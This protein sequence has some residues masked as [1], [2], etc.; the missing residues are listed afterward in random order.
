[1]DA[2]KSF[3]KSIQKDR[4][5][6]YVILKVEKKDGINQF[7]IEDGN[8]R[9]YALRKLG[10]NDVMVPVLFQFSA[11]INI[12]ELMEVFYMLSVSKIIDVRDFSAIMDQMVIMNLGEIR[13]PDMS[14]LL[15][16]KVSPTPA[17]NHFKGTKIFNFF[18]AIFSGKY[19][20]YTHTEGF[21]IA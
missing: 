6:D 12:E 21:D 8:H 9:V 7:T 5:K 11:S 19:K 17:Y 16:E 15:T 20:A 14:T 4:I 10:L 18:D 2:W 1:M 3:T 13:M